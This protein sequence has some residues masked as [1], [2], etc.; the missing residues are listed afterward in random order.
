MIPNQTVPGPLQPF[1]PSQGRS[2]KKK[3]LKVFLSHRPISP[4]R[5]TVVIG[6]TAPPGAR[7]SPAV[8]FFGV[9]QLVLRIRDENGWVGPAGDGNELTL[10]AETRRDETRYCSC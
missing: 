6:I 10:S 9:P 5:E 1:A 7:F 3:K 8:K 2:K 4:Y